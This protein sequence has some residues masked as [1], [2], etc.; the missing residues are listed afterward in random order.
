MIA[1]SSWWGCA[2]IIGWRLQR[3]VLLSLL[4][5][6]LAGILSLTTALLHDVFFLD[7]GWGVE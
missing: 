3:G 1:V 2:I 5:F 4:L 7:H 6:M